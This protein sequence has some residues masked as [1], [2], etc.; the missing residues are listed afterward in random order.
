MDSCS[1]N[2]PNQTKTVRC[3]NCSSEWIEPLSNPEIRKACPKH[4]HTIAI[5][6]FPGYLCDQCKSEGYTAQ[7][8]F[9]FSAPR[10]FKNGKEIK[11][12]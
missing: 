9:G 10:I 11:L 2:N 7:G 5:C 12:N 6:G 1:C 8:G 3:L 4:G